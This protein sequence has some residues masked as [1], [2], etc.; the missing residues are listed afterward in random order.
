MN[1]EEVL[2]AIEDGETAYDLLYD[3]NPDFEKRFKRMCRTMREFLADVEKEFP[4]AQ[5]YTAGGGFH[6]MLGAPHDDGPNQ[7][8]QVQLLALTGNGVKIGDGDF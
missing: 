3:A 6:L 8:A 1:E 7:R 4:G 2:A 5:Y